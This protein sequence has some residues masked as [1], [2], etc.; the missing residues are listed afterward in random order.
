MRFNLI[1]RLDDLHVEFT[2]SA[3]VAVTATDGKAVDRRMKLFEAIGGAGIIGQHGNGEL[4]GVE[5]H[6]CAPACDKHEL[7]G[8]AV[9]LGLPVGFLAQSIFTQGITHDTDSY[10]Q[11]DRHYQEQYGHG[12]GDGVH[13][14]WQ[15]RWVSLPLS[16]NTPAFC[17]G[18][19]HWNRKPWAVNSL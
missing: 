3:H 18:S 11:H 17:A 16:M 19:S 10:E 13:C 15:L 9:L 5:I 7:M 2:P 1:E 12:E 8:A 6:A 14:Y 4:L